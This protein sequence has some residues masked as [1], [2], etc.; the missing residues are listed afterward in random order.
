MSHKCILESRDVVFFEN[1]FPFSNKVPIQSS[2][3]DSLPPPVLFESF[4]SSVP[5]QSPLHD[6]SSTNLQLLADNDTAS[7]TLSTSDCTINHH[8][9]DVDLRR[10]SRVRQSP[11][12]LQDYVHIAHPNLNL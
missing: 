6:M 1:N 9:A 5:S 8:I 4:S 2:T 12:W 3:S 10:S 7:N 11:V